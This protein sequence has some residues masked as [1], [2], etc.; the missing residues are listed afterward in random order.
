VGVVVRKPIKGERD[1]G[2]RCSRNEL[3]S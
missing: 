1:E 3:Q 2:I